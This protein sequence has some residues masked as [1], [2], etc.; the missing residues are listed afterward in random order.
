MNEVSN[1]GGSVVA[2]SPLFPFPYTL[3]AIHYPL[4]TMNTD[5]TLRHHLLNL[6]DARQAHATF[7][8]IVKN[9]PAELQGERP[10]GLPY[11]PWELLEH[12]RITQFDILDFCQNP[13]YEE[14]AW[15]DDY[16]PDAAAPPTDTAWRQSVEAF[17]RDLQ[18]MKDLV[19]DPD[20]DLCAEIPH[21]DGQTYLREALLVADHNAYHLGQ[22]VTVRRLLGAWPPK[23]R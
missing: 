15:P 5:A 17:R 11:S 14:R 9:L 1:G 21:G 18:A 10:E 16:W 13:D 23:D 2:L 7:D 6:L 12:L 8:D 20:T 3:L 19:A 22:L 4:P